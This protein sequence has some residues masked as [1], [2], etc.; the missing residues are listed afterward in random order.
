MG[1]IECSKYQYAKAST[2]LDQVVKNKR[3]IARRRFCIVSQ[4]QYFNLCPRSF[5]WER[6]KLYQ[7]TLAEI[8]FVMTCHNVTCSELGQKFHSSL[9]LKLA[10]DQLKTMN[11]N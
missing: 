7:M 8:L 1:E 11:F 2:Q 4:R 6:S 5:T 3:S 9:L 10:W